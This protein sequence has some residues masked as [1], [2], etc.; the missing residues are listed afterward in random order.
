[1]CVASVYE[2]CL[3]VFNHLTETFELSEPSFNP[4]CMALS[5]DGL[6]LA[7][8]S[9]QGTV[10]VY[11][12]VSQLRTEEYQAHNGPVKELDFFRSNKAIASVS[13]D[14]VACYDLNKRIIFRELTTERNSF[15]HVSV[16]PSGEILA[17]ADQFYGVSLFDLQRSS[18]IDTFPA[19]SGPI[20]RLEFLGD[21]SGVL[22]SSS[23]DKTL[24]LTNCFS[25]SRE[26]Q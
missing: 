18:L 16:E 19:H 21:G 15:E 3:R 11:N 24:K 22:L 8:G 17:A 14:K 20:T 12:M 25:E 9:T 13:G 2:Q 7:A 10:Y 1:M 4:T 6:L 5:P 23:W 26:S